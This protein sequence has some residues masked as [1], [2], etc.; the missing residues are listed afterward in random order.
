MRR[1]VPRSSII[2]IPSGEN[3]PILSRD[4]THAL[5]GPRQFFQSRAPSSPTSLDLLAVVSFH[6]AFKSAILV[7]P[8]N[9]FVRQ[10]TW[11]H[12]SIGATA[13]RQVGSPFVAKSAVR[14]L[15]DALGVMPEATIFC[16]LVSS[17]SS[18]PFTAE[19]YSVAAMQPVAATLPPLTRR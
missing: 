18:T 16:N 6:A 11:I 7:S 5:M 4:S 19:P 10:A 9:R 2:V 8:S 13:A 1:D 3:Q 14:D 15:P 17:E 12:W